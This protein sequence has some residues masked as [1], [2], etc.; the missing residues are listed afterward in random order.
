MKTGKQKVHAT[1]QRFTQIEDIVGQITLFSGS[2]AALVM[3]VTATNFALQSDQEQQSRIYSYA[4][5]LN[6]LSFPIQILILSRRLDITSYIRQLEAQSKRTTNQALAQQISMYKDFVA[7]LVRNNTVLD[8]KFYIVVS[9]S[10]LEKGAKGAAG[11]K[12]LQAFYNE[13]RAQLSLKASSIVQQLI[14][15]GLKS[16]ILEKDELVN[17][18]HGIYNPDSGSANA[19]MSSVFVKGAKL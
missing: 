18:F 9:Y 10:A 6:S 14:R 17:L 4:A 12:N 8:K 19:G 2:Q 5:L 7:Q 3:E 1:T 11:S 15:V 13:A 16:R